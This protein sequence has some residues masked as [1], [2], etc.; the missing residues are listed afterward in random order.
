MKIAQICFSGLGGHSSVVFS[1]IGAS[2]KL[3]SNIVWDIGFIG[4]ETISKENLTQC[5][6]LKVPNLFI[7]YSPGRQVFAWYKLLI[8]LRNSQPN[9]LF[10]HSPS[11]IFPCF[12][13]CILNSARLITIEHTANDV[14]NFKE[15]FFSFISL[16][17]SNR[18]IVL[19]SEYLKNLTRV[20]KFFNLHRR[21]K[22][23]PNG[24]DAE[25][26]KTNESC[27]LKS[28]KILIGMA[29]RFTKIKRHDLLIKS[30]KLLNEKKKDLN[31]ILLFAG[32]GETLS[33]NQ[34][35]VEKNNMNDCIHFLG[36]LN[37]DELL[38]WFHSL[39]IY[40]H[41]AEAENLST[42]ILQ[43][44]S[45]EKY[46]IASKV[47]GIENLLFQEERYGFTCE[48]SPLAFA[49]KILDVI[50]SSGK[51]IKI[52]RRARKKILMN[53]TNEQMLKSYLSVLTK[54]D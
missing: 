16:I 7:K 50:N 2:K 12:L 33:E 19:T 51:Y 25:I 31:I 49:N 29:S 41:A 11:M 45:M 36:L 52:T 20:E 35:L 15:K 24:I 44:M 27:S 37:Q 26:Y 8:W 38:K 28:K 17:F 43:A 23:I 13:Y 34:K 14:K 47:A 32:D 5:I 22:V 30:M 40:V 18:V 6:K 4:N 10:C 42:S 1:L 48:N 21:Y 9:A 46:I 54:Q 39:D 53:Y 3:N